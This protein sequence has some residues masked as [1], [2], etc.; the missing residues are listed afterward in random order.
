MSRREIE[1]NPITDFLHNG[2]PPP[3]GNGIAKGNVFYV[4]KQSDNPVSQ[5]IEITTFSKSNEPTLQ[6]VRNT[7]DLVNVLSGGKEI[8]ESTTTR[9]GRMIRALAR[10]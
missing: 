2:T 4:G 3:E 5:K 10:G 1:S 6:I 7:R 8:Q 9:L